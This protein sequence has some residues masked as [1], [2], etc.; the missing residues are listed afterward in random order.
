MEEL[1]T[2][3]SYEEALSSWAK[4]AVADEDEYVVLEGRP[5][6]KITLECIEVGIS[7]IVRVF[8]T[9]FSQVLYDL[10]NKIDFYL[11]KVILSS[12]DFQTIYETVYW[13]RLE[14]EYCCGYCGYPAFSYDFEQVFKEFCSL[15][16]LEIQY[17]KFSGLNVVNL[18]LS[19][20]HLDIREHITNVYAENNGINYLKNLESLILDENATNGTVLDLPKLR[21]LLVVGVN[22]ASG[23]K[24]HCRTAFIEKVKNN[25]GIYI[26]Y[27]S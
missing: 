7:E 3:S 2:P 26:G 5:V 16:H 15:E 17:Y 22:N 20:R 12:T 13:M 1:K 4:R 27:G 24:A 11:P 8:K 19:L 21:N 18:P 10:F 23:S 14:G 9:K 25:P 6:T